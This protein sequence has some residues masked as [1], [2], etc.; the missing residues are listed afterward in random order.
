MGIEGT[1]VARGKGFIGSMAWLR[2]TFISLNR[3]LGAGREFAAN[4]IIG[5]ML[6]KRPSESDDIVV[7]SVSKW[8]E[9]PMILLDSE[10]LQ[11]DRSA[12][13]IMSLSIATG[14]D[15]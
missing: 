9:G 7:S 1:T 10:Y 3:K 5:N 4:C 2:F 12:D 6:P 11:G 14:D 15:K 8:E 13:A